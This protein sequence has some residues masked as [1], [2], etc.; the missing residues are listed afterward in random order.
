MKAFI[1]GCVLL[2]FVL[3][4]SGCAAAWFLVGAGAAATT[5]AVVD[6]NKKAET[7]K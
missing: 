3:S 6:E 5:M 7:K 1:T 4:M 2:G